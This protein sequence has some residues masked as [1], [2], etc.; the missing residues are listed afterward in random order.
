[1][2]LL[3]FLLPD[4]LIGLGAPWQLLGTMWRALAA[5]VVYGLGVH[6]SSL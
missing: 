1:V 4:H 3:H 2:R 5:D 6:G